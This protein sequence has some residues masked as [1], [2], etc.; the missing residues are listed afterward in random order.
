M[1][2]EGI[3]IESIKIERGGRQ[4]ERERSNVQTMK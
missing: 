4:R 2:I 1:K 3:K